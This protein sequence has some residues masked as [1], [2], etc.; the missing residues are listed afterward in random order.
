MHLHIGVVSAY[1]DKE[2]F[3][4]HKKQLLIFPPLC[5]ATFFGVSFLLRTLPALLNGLVFLHYFGIFIMF[6]CK[7]LVF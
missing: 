4:N 1:L 3:D 2:T 5:V 7:N 6:I